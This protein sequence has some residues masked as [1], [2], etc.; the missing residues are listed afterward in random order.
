MKRF[1]LMAAAATAMLT[2]CEKTEMVPTGDAQEISFVAVNKTATKVP[3]AD[4]KFLDTDNMAIAAYIV[5]GTSPNDFF[6]YTLFAKETGATNWTGQPARYW[7]LTTSKIN[8]LAVTVKGG[9]VENTTVDF[10]ATNY[11]SGA[12]AVLDNNDTYDQNDLMFAAGTGTHTQG[13]A[14]S[15]VEMVFKHALAWINFQVKT[16]T[17]VSTSHNDEG[18]EITVNSI[19]L[20]NAAFNGTLTLENNQYTSTDA[21]TTNSVN[22]SWSS[23][24]NIN[25]AVPNADGDDIADPV[26]LSSQWKLFGNGLLVIPDHYATSFT[27]NYTL[28]QSDGTENTFDYTYTLPTG[29][30]EMAK[31]Y[32][33]NINITLSE[34]EITPSITDWDAS[35][36]NVNQ[37]VD[38]IN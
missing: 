36:S 29:T 13:N 34:I 19:T 15:A 6:G 5:E 38:L 1:L 4:N 7:P 35:H 9:G 3:V 14:Y 10:N 18:C 8:F 32:F 11:A 20:N 31:K 28:K 21:N 22:T 37:G 17:P 30:W 16:T 23:S 12:T 24:E 2:A 27:I 33:Y 25:L 26:I